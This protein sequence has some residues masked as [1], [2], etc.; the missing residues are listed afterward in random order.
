MIFTLINAMFIIINW[1]KSWKL[2][3]KKVYK[4]IFI[5]S[6]RVCNMFKWTFTFEMPFTPSWTDQFKPRPLMCPMGGSTSPKNAVCLLMLNMYCYDVHWACI[7][8]MLYK[9]GNLE[10]LQFRKLRYVWFNSKSPENVNDNI[11]CSL[12]MESWTTSGLLQS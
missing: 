3:L 2:I 1:Y 10:F 9:R 6:L 12:F 5:F 4:L 7:A 8:M 11:K